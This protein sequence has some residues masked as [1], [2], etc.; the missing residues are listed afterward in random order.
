MF[1][2]ILMILSLS[3]A[4]HSVLA[5]EVPRRKSG[6]WEISM[7]VQGAPAPMVS[8][9]CIDQQTDDITRSMGMQPGKPV[10]SRNE[11]RRDGSRYISESVCKTGNTTTTTRGVFAGD[12]SQSYTGE[13]TSSFDPPV[14]GRK[15]SAMVFKARWTGPCKAGMK[16]GD[17]I[18][19][20]GMKFNFNDQKAV[21]KK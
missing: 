20:G 4:A 6:L 18:M 14:A 13:L 2:A 7:N 8:Q 9:M 1:R 11:F 21:A 15:D 3:M 12:F 19:P 10:C 16:P 5:Q 17:M